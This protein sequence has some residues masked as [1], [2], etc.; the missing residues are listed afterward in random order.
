MK[1]LAQYD[2]IDGC[3]VTIPLVISLV[4]LKYYLPRKKSL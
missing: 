1:F 2:I 3:Y 4:V